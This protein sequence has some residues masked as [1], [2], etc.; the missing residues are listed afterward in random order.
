MSRYPGIPWPWATL[1]VVVALVG[2][3]WLLL[4]S[5]AEPGFAATAYRMGLATLGTLSLAL[6]ILPRRRL[7]YVL[8][9]AV[10]ASLIA[11]ALWLQFGLGLEPCPLCAFQRIAVAALGVL[12]LVAALHN[13]G[14][15]G[16]IVYAG[17]AFV[18]GAAGAGLA[19]WHVWIQAQPKAAAQACGSGLAYLL[20]SLPLSAV[21][22]TVLNGSGDCAEQGWQF[23]GLGIP[24]WTFAFFVAMVA[25]ALATARAD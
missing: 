19:G 2:Q 14:P 5:G 12:F 13:P 10:C 23:L 6:I 8:G 21:V 16:A 4:H 24:A 18:V 20:E 25:A 7:A 9:F 3:H 1:A 22:G 17:L 15:I 11:W